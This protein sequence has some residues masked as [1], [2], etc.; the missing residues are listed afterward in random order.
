M[1]FSIYQQDLSRVPRGFAFGDYKYL[2]KTSYIQPK[3]YKLVWL[4]ELSEE[5]KP[6]QYFL[7][8]LWVRFNLDHPKNYYG[9]SMSVS[10]II[11]IYNP[12][13]Q[14]HEYYFVDAFGF[15]KLDSWKEEN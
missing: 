4:D 3:Y 6:I 13:N 15:K 8:D 12:E 7:S 1:E 10:D 11:R 9:R 2:S 5:N 14:C